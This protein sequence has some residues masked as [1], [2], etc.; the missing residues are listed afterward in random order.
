MNASLTFVPHPSVPESRTGS[1]ISLIFFKLNAPEN[2][3]F[4][5]I[6]NAG[7]VPAGGKFAVSGFRIFGFG[8]GTAP[9]SA[10]QFRARRCEDDR[11]MRVTWES[12]PGA[13]GYIIRFGVN[14]EELNTHWQV[15]GGNEAL[16]RCLTSGISY[17]VC[18]DA[19]NENGVTKGTE[20]Q[21]V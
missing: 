13:E 4:I 18:V 7:A 9:G 6:T 17:F 21:K 16:I 14:R 20:I 8:C 3:R 19:Y 1:S 12:V 2:L 10:P 15:I 11:D 5:R